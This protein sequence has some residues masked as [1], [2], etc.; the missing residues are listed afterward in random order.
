[1]KSRKM[2]RTAG[3]VAVAAAATLAATPARAAPEAN[4]EA[5]AHSRVN[6]DEMRVMLGTDRTGPQPAVLNDAVVQA[7]NTALAQARQNPRIKARLAGIYTSPQYTSQGKPEGYRVSGQIELE[8]RDFAALAA[9]AGDLGQKLQLQGIQ[10][11]VSTERRTEEEAALLKQAAAAFQAKAQAMAEAFGF[12]SYK[13]KS[14]SLG[15]QFPG[16]PPMMRAER[17][18]YGASDKAVAASLPID[19]GD[20]EISLTV[21]GQIELQ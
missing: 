7:L 11:R 5:A 3:A 21:S 19:G 6:N 17:M 8:S 18:S 12:R 16:S 15:T 1:M 20:A 10:F 14:V 2:I 4:L 13:I 9:L